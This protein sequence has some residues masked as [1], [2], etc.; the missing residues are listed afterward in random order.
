MR[1]LKIYLATL[2]LVSIFMFFGGYT[3][4][5]FREHFWLAIAA[6]AFIIAVLV[7]VF[8]SQDERIEQLEAKIKE[9]E[10][11]E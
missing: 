5:N 7:S 10:E 2:V 9:I 11:K 4:F 8:I 1:F 3:L 6:C